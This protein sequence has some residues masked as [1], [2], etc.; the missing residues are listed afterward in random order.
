MPAWL[1][2][3]GWLLM[4]L[5]S[6]PVGAGAGTQVL[7]TGE[8]PPY[9]GVNEPEGGSMA[10]V[11]RAVYAAQGDE[12][13]LGFFGWFR[14]ARLQAD[15]SGFAA[16]FPHYY[17]EE[18]AA[19][20][21][22]SRP[23]GS[24]PLGLATRVG[25]QLHWKELADLQRYR[26]GMVKSYVSVPALD[27]L[28]AARKVRT[29]SALDDADNLRNLLAGKVDAVVIDRNVFAYL[30]RSDAFRGSATQL[31]LDPRVLVMH[32][33]YMCFSRTPRGLAA[34]DSFDA[35]LARLQES[36]LR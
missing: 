30:Q 25:T 14:I 7:L 9:T 17:S 34:R 27:R 33:L 18:R 16:S 35:G 8:W 26:I 24:S 2:P 29:M 15:D 22:F 31:R 32:D 1:Q 19:R 11:V 23:I 4:A 12:V 13:R 5:L 3:Q 28:V 20:C 36:A 6:F 10:A 21:H